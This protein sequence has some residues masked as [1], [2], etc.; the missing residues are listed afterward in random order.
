M[1]GQTQ[2]NESARRNG[3]GAAFRENLSG[4][5]HDV[6]ELGELQMQLLTVDL[7]EARRR[8]VLAIVLVGSAL[9]LALS[10]VPVLLLGI[11]WALVAW[12]GWTHAAAFA[13]TAVVA[14]LLA[15][16]LAWLAWRRL[17]AAIG[18]LSRSGEEFATNVRWIK[19]ALKQNSSPSRRSR[20]SRATFDDGSQKRTSLR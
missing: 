16:G 12:A 8:S 1:G 9:V 3:A 13:I 11:G 18:K 17:N 10:S 19:D 14:L 20:R 7:A 6:I 4:L 5:L 2:I 15:A